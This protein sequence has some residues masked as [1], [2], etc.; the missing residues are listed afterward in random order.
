MTTTKN[1]TAFSFATPAATG[2]INGS[3]IVVKVPNSTDVTVL[4]ATFTITGASVEVDSVAQTSGVTANDFTGNVTYTVIADDASEKDYTVTVLISEVTLLEIARLRRLIAEPLTTTYSDA[5]LREYIE[6]YA[7]TDLSGETP[8]TYL[9]E[10]NPDWTPTFDLQA[11]AGDIWEEKATTVITRFAYSAD[12]GN[13]S[14][15]QVYEQM[16]KQARSCRSRRMPG[17]VMGVKSPEEDNGERFP[18]IGNL[19]EVD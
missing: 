1:I 16:M 19:P 13:Y 18:W 17:S 3:K 8:L 5:L 4:I 11:A 6:R 14:V 2:A 7:H 9:G 12:G 15:N 10:V